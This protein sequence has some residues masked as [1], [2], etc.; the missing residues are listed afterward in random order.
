[1]G[2]KCMY[3]CGFQ[4]YNVGFYT[5]RFQGTDQLI[6]LNSLKHRGNWVDVYHLL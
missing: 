2:I 4:T 5:T 3:I 6:A 1:M